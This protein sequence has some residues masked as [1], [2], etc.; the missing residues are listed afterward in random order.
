MRSWE[1]VYGR[2]HETTTIRPYLVLAAALVASDVHRANADVQGF[3]Q[4]NTCITTGGTGAGATAWTNPDS[5][6]SNP[7]TAATEA[8]SSL[9]GSSSSQYL[10]CNDFRFT[11]PTGSVID[12]VTM[13]ATHRQTGGAIADAHV[14]PVQPGGA[15]IGSVGTDRAKT[16]CMTDTWTTASNTVVYANAALPPWGI[17]WGACAA[18]QTTCADPAGSFNVNNT[19]FGAAIA[20]KN[21]TGGACHGTRGHSRDAGDLHGHPM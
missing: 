21:C 13:R 5:A 15:A 4:A 16:S 10:A 8:T 14:Y 6:S 11:V 3:T 20:A 1:L 18:S 17:T 9:P 19:A 7:M 12:A 2:K